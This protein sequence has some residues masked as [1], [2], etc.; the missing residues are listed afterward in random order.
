MSKRIRAYKTSPRPRAGGFVQIR[1]FSKINLILDVLGKRPDGYH[2]VR[3]VMQTLA[4]HDMLTISIVPTQRERFQLECSNPNLPTDERNLV[5]RAARYMIQEY[6]ITL[7]VHIHLEKRIPI[8]AGLAGGSSDCAATLAGLNN[9]FNLNIPMFCDTLETECE[10]QQKVHKNA[11]H[12]V[13]QQSLMAIGLRFGADVPFCLLGGTALA[14]GI[15]ERLTPLT[16]HPHCWVVLACPN[17]RVSTKSV[18]GRVNLDTISPNNATAMINA[19][20]QG[21]LQQIAANLSNDLTKVTAA[22]HPVIYDL[23]DEMKNQG[24]TGASMSGSGPSVFGYFSNRES[25]KKAQKNLENIAG[26]AFLTE[27]VNIAGGA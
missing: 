10:A 2:D 5:T 27:I 24:A 8:A 22:I 9:L 15:G 17:I 26:R 1:A 25:A 14:E 13:K 11:L 3:T 23:I 21:S 4:L 20:T 16:P 6:D 18:F 12:S 7:P 19:L